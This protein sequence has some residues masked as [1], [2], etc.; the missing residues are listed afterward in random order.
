[1]LSPALAQSTAAPATDPAIIGILAASAL[2]VAAIAWALRVSSAARNASAVWTGKLAEMEAQ[3]EKS[4]SVLAA[5]PGL[6]LVWEDD[7]DAIEQGWGTP[8][9]LGGPAALASLMS[10]SK[11]DDD[12][13]ATP[14]TRLL[15]TLG[16]LPLEDDG[17]PEDF[18]KLRE[19]VRE[20]REHG[21]AFSGSVMTHEGRAIEADGR[22]AG[23]QVALWLTDPAVRMAEDGG[24]L[25]KVREKTADLHGALAQLD[26]APVPAWRRNSDLSLSWV[27][28]AYVE[29]VEA[30]SASVVLKDQMELDSAVRRIAERA[31]NERRPAEGRVTLNIKGV[32]R[33]LKVSEA[34]MHSAGDASVAGFAIDITELERTRGDLNQHI[35]A[36]KNTLDQV[37]AAVA[38]F[39]GG[40]DLVYYNAAF[41]RM[42]ELED[43]DLGARPAHGELLDRL[44]QQGKLP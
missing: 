19:K 30:P 14:V 40:Q 4:D 7:Y 9:I 32:R 34:P 8:K 18:K 5:H 20:L 6:V 27:N 38:L 3:L 12:P 37:P 35:E 11:K 16:D 41:R 29:A 17:A 15:S 31:A 25:G 1:M 13:F 42:W 33:V 36:N 44:R 22:V 43:A 21:I 23:S 26:R 24:I 39:G 10:F 28:A 2:T